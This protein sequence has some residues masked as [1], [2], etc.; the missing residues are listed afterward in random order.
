MIRL[1]AL[2]WLVRAVLLVSA[3]ALAMPGKD[4][5]SV[6]NLEPSIGGAVPVTPGAAAAWLFRRMVPAR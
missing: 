4:V 5:I 3:M 6:D 1:I 2:Q